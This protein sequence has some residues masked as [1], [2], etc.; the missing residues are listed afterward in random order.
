MARKA[1]VQKP[2]TLPPER[3]LKALTQQLDGLQK[4]KGRHYPDA[5]AEE[6]EWIQFT[7][8]IIEAAFG[9][10][11]SSLS[12]FYMAGHAGAHFIGGM[13]PQ[14]HQ[15]NFELRGREFDALL[16]GLIGV[17]QLQLPEDTINATYAPGEQYDFY[18]DLSVLMA[19][20]TREIFIVDAYLN[21]DV[22]NLYV[23]KV[24]ATAKVRVL[25]NKIGANVQ[26]VATMYAKNRP[27]ELRSSGAIHDRAIFF[28]DRGCIIGQSIKDAAGKKPTYLIELDEPA[29]TA[30]R[31]SHDAIW[32]AATVVI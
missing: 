31:A 29:L 6:T 20:A 13:S 19:T 8:G 5:D 2:P 11:S 4:L 23:D 21:E 3:A 30:I 1:V 24:P 32:A 12:K 16:R 10:P 27:L 15:T 28:D 7:Q 22:F 9:D 18:R 25:S 26:A 17:L 14:Q